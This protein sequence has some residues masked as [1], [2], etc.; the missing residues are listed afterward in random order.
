MVLLRLM[1]NQEI[2]FFVIRV[3]K[4]IAFSHIFIT[5]TL[6]LIRNLLGKSSHGTISF[7]LQSQQSKC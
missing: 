1:Y 2:H 5:E 6:V 3:I 4:L 7:T